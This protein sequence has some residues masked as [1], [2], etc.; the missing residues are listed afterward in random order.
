MSTKL[1]LLFVVSLSTSG[2]AGNPPS[3]AHAHKLH[4]SVLLPA[5]LRRFQAVRVQFSP[6]GCERYTILGDT[7][8]D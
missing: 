1:L 2:F 8:P 3:F 4:T 6:S 7:H 5:F